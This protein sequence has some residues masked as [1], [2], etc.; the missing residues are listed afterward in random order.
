MGGCASRG[1]VATYADTPRLTGG[2]KMRQPRGKTKKGRRM[3]V[4]VQGGGIT[5][6]VK[7]SAS[8]QQS[9]SPFCG[10]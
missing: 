9:G 10:K 6:I 1:T 2:S 5:S 4:P 3:Q 7:E 8:R